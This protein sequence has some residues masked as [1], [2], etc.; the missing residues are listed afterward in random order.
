[1]SEELL[2]LGLA[3]HRA[4]R[5][6]EAEGLYQQILQQNPHHARALQLVGLIAHQ[7]GR[8]EI[9][10]DL[11]RRAIAIEPNTPSFHSN[12]GMVLRSLQQP[13]EAAAC[14]KRAISLFPEDPVARN[15]L[16][17]ALG[18]LRKLGDARSAFE[19]AIA[20]KPD[21]AEAHN[22]LGIL[23]GNQG[24][25]SEATAS[26]LAALAI[27][28]RFAQAQNNLGNC[29]R[30]MGQREKGKALYRK[31]IELDPGYA[32]AFGNLGV[33]LSELGELSESESAF[34]R[35]LELDPTNTAIRSGLLMTLQY[36][37][38]MSPEE[39][40]AEH[41]RYQSQVD[42][43]LAQTFQHPNDRSLERRLRVGYVSPDFRTHSV[44]Y[45]IEEILR[46][47][48]REKFE[49]FAYSDVVVP[50]A[51]TMQLQHFADCWRDI[52]GLSHAAVAES[53]RADR[54][55]VLVD[56][57]G[58]TGNN[59]LPVF[60]RKP[61]PVQVTYLGY[62][63][64]T[65]LTA[66]DYRITDDWADP[67]GQT[68]KVH[69]EQLIRLPPGFLIYK[70]PSSAGEVGLSTLPQGRVRFASFNNIA[71]V[72]SEVVALWSLVLEAVPTST[73]L[74]KSFGLKDP[75]AQDRVSR[76]FAARGISPERIQTLPAIDSRQA[77]HLHLYDQVDIALDTF[78]YCGTTT[79][80]EALWMGVPVI[81]LAGG[82]HS[83]RVGLSLLSRIGRPELIAT[84]PEDFVAIA[85]R[86]ANSRETLVTL[87]MTLRR[88]MQDS[89]L[90]NASLV[91]AALE[92]E[93]RK[94]WLRWIDS[95][96]A[97]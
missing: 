50:D 64:T 43:P 58:H 24:R 74:L 14:F 63:A 96:I 73:L 1:V 86:L 88:Q 34:R 3:H 23:H 66:V 71:K 65:G 4:G 61:A 84:S 51:T 15:N 70:P 25:L 33:V 56:L 40:Y 44:A 26:Y 41:L 2:A 8:H 36:G 67:V 97:V 39:L 75:E 81:T 52:H 94:M 5:L 79:T 6:T 45:F 69:S 16:G 35:A 29:Y 76:Q 7:S 38:G 77:E 46:V 93:Y 82:T 48:D 55:D 60:A 72:N 10:A 28:P 83:S 37:A 20:L 59:R 22:N 95:F 13:E 57:A 30:L 85:T 11:I 54:I 19:S 27:N 53:I 42:V 21:Y 92:N 49:V 78:P 62:P 68:E 89:S 91:T 18:D 47:H 90:M 80:C 32:V 12:L 17:L 9:A 31:A 87:R